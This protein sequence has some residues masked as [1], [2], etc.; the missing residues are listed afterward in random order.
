MRPVKISDGTPSGAKTFTITPRGLNDTVS[1]AGVGLDKALANYA[2]WYKNEVL[3]GCKY[4]PY[5]SQ[6]ALTKSTLAPN[7]FC[8]PRTP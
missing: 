5:K 3:P 2:S 4:F 1:D 7:W 8:Y 6:Q